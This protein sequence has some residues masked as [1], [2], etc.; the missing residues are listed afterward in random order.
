MGLS[1]L[2]SE[3]LLTE[4]GER[5]L[6]LALE[7]GARSI[8]ADE[9]YALGFRYPGWRGGGLLL[10]FG[11][12]FAQLR[13]DAPP[14]NRHGDPIKY[15]NR[16]G[17]KQR[18]VTFGKDSP[19]TAT[20]GWKDAIRLHLET[21]E[22][23][24]GIPGVTVGKLLAPTVHY[25]IFD[26]DATTN[27]SVWGQLIAASLRRPALRLGF[28]PRELAGNKG[29]ACEFFNAGGELATIRRWKVRELLRE[30]PNQWDRTLRIDWQ[31]PAIRKLASLALEAT[32]SRDAAQQL[33]SFAAKQI[34]LPVERAR[35]ILYA[36]QRRRNP[37]LGVPPCQ[38]VPVSRNDA[39]P[40]RQAA[41][42]LYSELGRLVACAGGRLYRYDA[43]A[44]YWQVWPDAE[45]EAATLAV[46][47]RLFDISE[48]T[49]RR[50]F[51]YGTD[52]QMRAA[53][54]LLARI[55]GRGP[56]ASR[57]PM[58]VVFGNGTLDLRTCRLD[59]HSPEHGATFGIDADYIPGA[60]CPAA[61][62]RVLETCFPEG[63][64]PII[65]A[66]IRWAI[67]PTIRYGE[68]FHILGSTGTGKGLTLEF[69]GSML[70]T[71]LQSS[72]SHP[73]DIN[74][75][76]TLH[77]LV[78]GR[79][80]ILFP[81]TP[82][83]NRRRGHC[84]LFYEL[85]ENKPQTT[86]RLYSSDAEEARRMYARCIIGSIAPLQF[87]D[88][89]D[90]F[91]RRVLTLQ[92]LPRSC[93][94]DPTL[95]DRLIGNTQEHRQ[96]RSEAASWALGMFL[97]VVEAVL[98]KSD[99]EGLL[100]QGEEEAAAAGDPVSLWA[101]VCLEPHHL[102]ANAQ[103][104][105]FDL[106]QMY[107]SYLGWCHYA[108]VQHAKQR[109]NFLGHLRRILG[110]S[111]CLPRHKESREEA[112]SAGRSVTQRQN[113]PRFDAGFALRA[114]VLL[115]SVTGGPGDRSNFNRLALGSGALEA[116]RSL[117]PA[118]RPPHPA[119][120]ET[121]YA[122]DLPASD[123][124]EDVIPFGEFDQADSPEIT[125][126]SHGRAPRR[127]RVVSGQTPHPG[128]PA[129]ATVLSNE[130]RW[131]QDCQFSTSKKVNSR[132]INPNEDKY[133]DSYQE[134]KFLVDNPE[135]T[136]IRVD[137]ESG[138]QLPIPFGALP[139]GET[140]RVTVVSPNGTSHSVERSRITP[141]SQAGVAGGTQG[142]S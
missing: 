16:T 3:H 13:C 124:E 84:G 40:E 36:Q 136:P 89:R 63:A 12:D 118:L 5:G 138:W 81:D 54:S 132:E 121:T 116:I 99:P 80:L 57:E 123:Q 79:R 111:R 75:P 69:V 1:D 28:F 19:T 42:L 128:A 114:G 62:Q 113:R 105:D 41:E 135:T 126:G 8:D 66:L 117:S 31:V 32:L 77:Q 37:Q 120:P 130:E 53:V 9:A 48:K 102:G 96:I 43:R 23:V 49:G 17:T 85:V 4:L 11:G 26:A 92:T 38:G 142:R 72:I 110:P 10:P 140:C 107:E 95:R 56:L 24:Q 137:D 58:V 71:P 122:T 83:E 88:S 34:G 29:G 64:E 139:Q 21:G 78:Q 91:L 25:L 60:A 20:E 47:Q 106:D 50:Q 51:A 94:P 52:H 39:P 6:K 61:L 70:P 45:A 93:D 98:D 104:N 46:L 2:H 100:R 18:P 15:L 22:T 55:A 131:S 65:R 90:G 76:E 68:A 133:L 97:E 115:P 129:G 82:A 101:D 74:S 59:D 67:D 87:G 127:A 35:Q 14:I 103:V 112:R 27:P 119:T 134:K 125:T 33:V 30:L 44:G 7:L 109:N 108:G 86:R 73:A 141:A